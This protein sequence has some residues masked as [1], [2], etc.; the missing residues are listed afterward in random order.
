[1]VD[2]LHLSDR[3]LQHI[4]LKILKPT[5][6]YVMNP[7]CYHLQGPSGV[8]AATKRILRV[9]E[10]EKPQYIIRADIKSF[11]KSIPHNKLIQDIKQHYD[12]PKVQAMLD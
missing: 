4:L 2:Q 1:M 7:N 9:P 12:D 8:K 5:F 10:A 6:T 11:Y 3:V